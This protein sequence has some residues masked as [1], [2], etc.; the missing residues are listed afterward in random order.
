MCTRYYDGSDGYF[1]G[2]SLGGLRNVFQRAI[3]E[4]DREHSLNPCVD[5]MLNYFCH[6]FFPLCD[7]AT[8]EII[9]VCGRS[10]TL[11]TNNQN[12]SA[13]RD[14]INDE[15]E[16]ES[17]ASTGDTCGQTHRSFVNSPPVSE[18]CFAIEG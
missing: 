9:P 3:D 5:L 15:L 1:S 4:F 10:C 7:Q 13:L 14:I 12:C 6:Y 8:G 16:R 17:L 11:L 2:R 18:N